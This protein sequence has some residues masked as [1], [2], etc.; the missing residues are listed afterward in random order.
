MKNLL[1][2]ISIMGVLFSMITCSEDSVQ[3]QD[4]SQ[5]S[6]KTT[7]TTCYTGTAWA[8][9][10]RFVTR[11]NWATFNIVN[12]NPADGW[13]SVPLLAGQNI[14]A[15]YVGFYK[16]AGNDSMLIAVSLDPC[17][18]FQDVPEPIKIQ[19]YNAPY[20]TVIPI[21]GLFTTYK[22]V[23]TPDYFGTRLYYYA[24]V[25][26]NFTAYAVHVDVDFCPCPA[27]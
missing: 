22:G 25:D 17:W 5:A 1:K 9:G 27:P 13:Q 20:P 23:G 3:N 7:L 4:D 16:P 6:L 14:Y 18:S 8:A 21:P 19:G 11:G 24:I 26:P 10:T 15:G 12:L 2:L